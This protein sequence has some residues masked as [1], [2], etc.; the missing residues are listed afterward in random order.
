MP[1]PQVAARF[2][3]CVANAGTDDLTLGM[4]YRVLPDDDAQAENLLRIIDDSGADYLYPTARFVAIQA[5][6]AEIPK[7]LAAAAT[8]LA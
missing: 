1:D 5:P 8:N 6:E 4:L 3:V 2:A 7:L